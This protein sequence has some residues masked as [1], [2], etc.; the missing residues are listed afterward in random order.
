MQS[1]ALS[2][3]LCIVTE[4]RDPRKQGSQRVTSSFWGRFLIEV[5][6]H[7]SGGHR[8]GAGIYPIP[9]RRIPLSCHPRVTAWPTT[10]QPHVPHMTKAPVTV[11]ALWKVGEGPGAILGPDRGPCVAA[12]GAATPSGP[13]RQ[14]WRAGCDEAPAK[15]GTAQ[16]ARGARRAVSRCWPG[17]WPRG[18]APHGPW[19]TRPRPGGAPCL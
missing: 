5:T 3:A 8:M 2:A 18:R 11:R 6:R 4:Y 12:H 19:P 1:T 14:P 17:A 15:R 7:P 16:P 9:P 13:G 10:I